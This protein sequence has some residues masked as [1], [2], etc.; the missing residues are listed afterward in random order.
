MWAVE[1]ADEKVVVRDYSMV[2]LLVVAWAAEKD[3]RK[4][5]EMVDLKVVSS[6]VCLVM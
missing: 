5:A 4:V 3:A 2:A 1:S 6:V